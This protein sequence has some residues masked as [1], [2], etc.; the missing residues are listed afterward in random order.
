MYSRII[1][2]VR[3]LIDFAVLDPEFLKIKLDTVLTHV[4][5]EISENH[6]TI[7]KREGLFR[8]FF[9]NNFVDEQAKKSGEVLLLFFYVPLSLFFLDRKAGA[10]VELQSL[11]ES[12]T[13]DYVVRKM[14]D[15][16]R[17]DNLRKPLL[18]FRRQPLLLRMRLLRL[19]LCAK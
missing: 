14:T 17:M 8:E 13:L 9:H 2:W 19:H 3:K 4:K 16:Q 18:N 1:F 11:L 7:E 12:V 15:E 5:D 10:I 6:S